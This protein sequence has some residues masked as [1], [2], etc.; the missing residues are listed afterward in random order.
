MTFEE[1][2][3]KAGEGSR[4][5]SRWKALIVIPWVLGAV[6]MIHES[7]VRR[8]VAKRQRTTW[9]TII[10]HDGSNHDRYGYAFVVEGRTYPGWVVPR[11]KEKWTLRQR[12]V[13]YYDPSDPTKNALRD[14]GQESLS[15]LGPLPM[16]T[17]MTATVVLIILVLSR[18]PNGRSPSSPPTHPESR[19][20]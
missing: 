2:I 12:V 1:G 9:G 14:F 10:V 18:G 13:V 3:R 15:I 8:D 4:H 19:V 16:L 7:C 17:A 5:P 11:D 6:L 20:P